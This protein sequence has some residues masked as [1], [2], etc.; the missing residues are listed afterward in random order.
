[1]TKSTV[2]FTSIPDSAAAGEYIGKEIL[3]SFKDPDVVIVFA[4]SK[5][6]YVKLLEAIKKESKPKFLVG[7]SSAGEFTSENMGEGSVS[8]VAIQSDDM[9]F[10]ASIGNRI[11]ANPKKAAQEVVASFQGM[12]D[13]TYPHRSALIMADALAGYTD[14]LI[15]ELNQLTAGTYQF[16]GGGAGDDAKFSKTHVFFD[17]Q[18]ETNA[19]V[20]LEI[21]S[22][23]PLGIG[24]RHGWEKASKDMRV[25]EA[26]G[27]KLVSLNAMPAVEAFKAHAAS[28]G[29][30]FDVSEP[31]PFFLHNVIGIKTTNGYKL[32]VP[33]SVN[34][35][36]SILCASDIPQGAIVNIMK[37]TAK[38]ASLA[39]KEATEDALRQ[40]NGNESGVALVFDCVAT[41]L[42]TGREFSDELN[43][44]ATQLGNTPYVGCNTYGQ[45]SRVDG[46]F[47]GFHNCTAVVCVIPA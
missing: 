44:I 10:S 11:S 39:A 16:F 22:H 13:A 7:C 24:V 21:L 12:D 29:Q 33:L 37:T 5:Y 35:D 47:S 42:R 27:M 25:T 32:R 9:K 28:T 18:V 17:T 41:R 15:D 40:T 36:G 20:G 8:A 6:D 19:V 38:S 1:M 3:S 43:T 30:N 46:Q 26:D 31:V 34:N 45:I 14:T 2:V 23:V 4:S